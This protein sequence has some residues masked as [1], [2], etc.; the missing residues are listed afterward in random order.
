MVA[1]LQARVVD[2]RRIIRSFIAQADHLLRKLAIYGA[3]TAIT[4]K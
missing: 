1:M 3:E 4:R 2:I